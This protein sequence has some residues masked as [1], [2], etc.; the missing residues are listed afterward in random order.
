MCGFN[1]KSYQFDTHFWNKNV[2]QFTVNYILDI[3]QCED[4]DHANAIFRRATGSSVAS[5]KSWGK[6]LDFQRATLFCLGQRLSNHKTTRIAKHFV[7][8]WPPLPPW[9][10]LCPRATYLVLAS[11]LVPAGTML[12]TPAVLYPQNAFR[13]AA[14][15]LR[16]SN[17]VWLQTH[18]RRVF[19]FVSSW[20][21]LFEK[22]K[23]GAFASSYLRKMNRGSFT[24]CWSIR[25]VA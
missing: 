20:H 15:W 3:S 11:D 13:H 1:A 6:Y 4:T 23:E 5:P 21:A 7:G 17:M 10:R 12:V 8:P 25:A 22:R 19:F 14:N 16:S 18:L 9:Q 24:V 2:A